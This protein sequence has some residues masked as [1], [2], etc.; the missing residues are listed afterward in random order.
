MKKKAKA[1]KSLLSNEQVCYVCGCTGVHRHH[2]FF[3]TANR[4]LSEKYG[5]WVN[6]CPNHHNM[7]NESVHFNRQMDLALKAECQQKW[8]EIY[9]DRTEFRKIFGKSWL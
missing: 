3:N 6:L 1:S 2:I 4:K 9:G 8:E 7:S 5:C